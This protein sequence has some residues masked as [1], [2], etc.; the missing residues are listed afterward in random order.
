MT[1][2]PILCGEVDQPRRQGGIGASLMI[3]LIGKKDMYQ[4]RHLELNSWKNTRVG[5]AN[6]WNSMTE[7][8]YAEWL[9]YHNRVWYATEVFSKTVSS[10]LTNWE[11]AHASWSAVRRNSLILRNQREMRKL[12]K[13]GYHCPCPEKKIRD[14]KGN[15][16][17]VSDFQILS[18]NKIFITD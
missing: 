17:K 12:Y 5:L 15:K 13:K 18:L 2:L 1:F 10:L 6:C 14:K 16:E 4:N 8:C 3:E 7:S 9:R 11:G